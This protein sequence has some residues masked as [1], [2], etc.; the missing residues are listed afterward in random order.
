MSLFNSRLIPVGYGAIMYNGNSGGIASCY[1]FF[2]SQSDFFVSP[3]ISSSGMGTI[4]IGDID[5]YWTVMP[6]YRVEV[7]SANNYG[8]TLLLNGDN[9]SGVFPVNY[10]ISSANLSSSIKLYFKGTLI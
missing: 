8:G 6:G 3:S 7:Y 4:N 10:T 2:T 1:P 9:T 5:D